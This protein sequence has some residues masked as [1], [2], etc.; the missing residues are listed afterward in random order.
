MFVEPREMNKSELRVQKEFAARTVER[1]KVVRKLY[2]A[3]WK[4]LQRLTCSEKTALEEY[5]L[6]SVPMNSVLYLPENIDNFRAILGTELLKD[7]SPALVTQVT[8]ASLQRVQHLLSLIEKLE[9]MFL[10]APRLKEELTVYRGISK[11]HV[12]TWRQKVK[13]G[14]LWSNKSFISTTLSF[15]IATSF[16]FPDLE[17]MKHSVILQIILPPHT[18]IIPLPGNA[19]QKYADYLSQKQFFD[20]LRTGFDENEI[21]LNKNCVFKVVGKEKLTLNPE[22]DLRNTGLKSSDN[23][24]VLFTLR[25]IAEN[26]DQ[27]FT[28]GAEDILFNMVKT[29]NFHFYKQS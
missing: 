25:L 5:K 24:I 22:N 2:A 27:K 7:A 15:K 29:I 4:F 14:S 10:R 3:F 17:T 28:L 16:S 13:I 1:V 9:L 11:F 12:D 26:S 18:S 21:V 8:K 6:E 20:D 23:F 19:P